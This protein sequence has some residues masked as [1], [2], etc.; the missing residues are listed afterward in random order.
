[1]HALLEFHPIFIYQPHHI[2]YIDYIGHIDPAV[3]VKLCCTMV[4]KLYKRG[5]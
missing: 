2:D 5:I 3:N 1:M 4:S